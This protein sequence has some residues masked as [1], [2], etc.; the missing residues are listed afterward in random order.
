MVIK[1]EAV[2][3][4]DYQK[5]WTNYADTLFQFVLQT[6]DAKTRNRLADLL[7]EFIKLIPKA[8]KKDSLK[9]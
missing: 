2:N 9:T 1:K 4:E 7:N 8:S 5:R 6:E 3:Q